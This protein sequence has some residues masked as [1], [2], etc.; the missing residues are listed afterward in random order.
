MVVRPEVLDRFDDDVAIVM[1]APSV[2]G[3]VP[4]GPTLA[5]GDAVVLALVEGRTV[6]FDAEDAAVQMQTF[7]VGAPGLVMLDV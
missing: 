4:A 5:W 3:A 6:T 7:V 1:L 2:L